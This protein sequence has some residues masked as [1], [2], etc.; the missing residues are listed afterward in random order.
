MFRFLPRLE[1][2]LQDISML[3]IEI[4][5]EL[6]LHFGFYS[7]SF[8]FVVFGICIFKEFFLQLFLFQKLGF[9]FFFF[10]HVLKLLIFI[11]PWNGLNV[12]STLS[13]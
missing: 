12:N 7:F 2:R 11:Q 6:V 13:E 10:L 4:V 1:P 3:F 8:A 5:Q 9:T